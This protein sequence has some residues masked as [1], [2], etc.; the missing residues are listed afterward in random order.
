MTGDFLDVVLVAAMLLFAFAGYR[1]G[2]VIGVLSFVGF[3][4]G[5]VL[6]AKLAAPIAVAFVN[7]GG[8]VGPI[9][10]LVV[11]FVFASLGQLTATAVGASVRN[12]LTSAPVRVVDS[13]GGAAVSG[14]SVLLIAWLVGSAVVISP[15]SGLATQVQRS[16]I[17]ATVD[18]VLPTSAH[19]WFSSFRRL[20]DQNGFPPVFSGI[21]RP[22]VTPVRPP[23]PAVAR[24]RAVR[25][26]TG[27]TVKIIGSAIC[28]RRL[29]G[30][31]FVYAPHRVLTNAHV[32]AGVRQPTVRFDGINYQATV[33][34]YDPQ[35]DVA[36][37]Y[38]RK[39]DAS[40]LSFAGPASSGDS[41]VVA[42]YPEDGPFT[43]V[44]ARVR[45]VQQARGP[46]IYQQQTLT[47]EIYALR[48]QVLP[49]NSGGPLL[50]PS[51]RVYGVVFAAATN[52]SSTGYALTAAEVA[53]DARAGRVATTSVSTQGCD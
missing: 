34:L 16:A 11:V 45:N 8:L 10:G 28:D 36:V 1:Q 26:A 50:D 43:A 49:G 15:F 6:G 30:S 25:V 35:R 17:L 41:A 29:E 38:A 53:S 7:G 31:G 18:Q 21:G 40:G 39:L 22:D 9:I 47:R 12:R 42:G 27:S 23:D 13:A 52:D 20:L 5:G 51:G 14:V 33:V 4:G 19:T 3:L 48:T 46:D 24:S 44:A 2:F 37:L 32:V